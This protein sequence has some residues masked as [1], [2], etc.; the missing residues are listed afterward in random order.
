MSNQFTTSIIVLNLNVLD[1]IEFT[2]KIRRQDLNI[3]KVLELKF[4]VHPG[5]VIINL[6]EFIN[7]HF[8]RYNSF[9]AREEVEEQVRFE[10]I[11]HSRNNRHTERRNFVNPGQSDS[12]IQ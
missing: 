2:I 5:K 12:S 8:N 9:R 3:T 10:N 11:I 7:S 4:K 1:I 6:W